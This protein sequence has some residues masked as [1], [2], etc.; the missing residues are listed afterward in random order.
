[1]L[2]PGLHAEERYLWVDALCIFQNDET[3]WHDQLNNLVSIFA[4]DDAVEE[5]NKA[6]LQGLGPDK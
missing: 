4:K 3:T 1:M 2:L 5:Y 6:R